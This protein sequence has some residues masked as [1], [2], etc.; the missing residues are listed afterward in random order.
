[1][2]L[3]DAHGQTV[4]L[5]HTLQYCRRIPTR[6]PR[7]SQTKNIDFNVSGLFGPIWQGVRPG[8]WEGHQT[9]RIARW[10]DNPCHPPDR[11]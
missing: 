7:D 4:F 3:G 9:T 5:I 2:P 8:R 10:L 1:M 6:S 11:N